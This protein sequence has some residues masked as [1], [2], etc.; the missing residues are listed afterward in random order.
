MRV[1]VKTSS[2]ESLLEIEPSVSKQEV[3][4]ENFETIK[5]EYVQEKPISSAGGLFASPGVRRLARELK[6]DLSII[7]VR[8]ERVE[9][10]NRT[11]ILI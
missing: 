8:E 2:S 9:L 11:Y 5:Q 3:H 4:Q 7:K 10:P 1:E 6:I